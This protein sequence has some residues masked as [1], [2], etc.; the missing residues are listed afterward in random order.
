RDWG[1]GLS[2]AGNP[3]GQG[4][5]SQTGDATWIHT[6]YNTSFWTTP[7]GDFSPTVSATTFVPGLGTF[8]WSSSGTIA[9]VQSWVSNPATNFGWIIIGDEVTA[10]SAAQLRS[11]E[12]GTSP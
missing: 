10:A 9:D 6:F 1:E 7:G 5:P 3:G 11:R 4:A 12:S 2:N 8:T